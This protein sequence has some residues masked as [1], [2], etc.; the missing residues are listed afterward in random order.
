[1]ANQGSLYL[2]SSKSN[3]KTIR[4]CNYYRDSANYFKLFG[5]TLFIET[6]RERDLNW[7]IY[8]IIPK[9]IEI[10]SLFNSHDSKLKSKEYNV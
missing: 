10:S 1:M 8:E 5:L 6:L 9:I 4:L 7:I 2:M 3:L